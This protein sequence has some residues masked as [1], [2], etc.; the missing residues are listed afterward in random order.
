ML[1]QKTFVLIAIGSVIARSDAAPNPFKQRFGVQVDSGSSNRDASKKHEK[2]TVNDHHFSPLFGGDF[3]DLDEEGM[4]GNNPPSR[5]SNTQNRQQAKK[6]QM[7]SS[8][9]K[10][11]HQADK[12]SNKKDGF[13]PSTS[14]WFCE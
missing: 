2:K 12:K 13:K 14:L 5:R 3:D 4:L 10:A 7:S 11:A 6:I 8:N 1:T 9:I